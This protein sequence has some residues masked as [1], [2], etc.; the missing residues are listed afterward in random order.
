N[1]KVGEPA[2]AD[3]STLKAHLPVTSTFVCAAPRTAQIAT[4]S[5]TTAPTAVIR[6]YILVISSP[7][8]LLRVGIS[9]LPVLLHQYPLRAGGLRV[10]GMLG[11]EGERLVR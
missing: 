8:F 5:I 2:P 3:V 7:S 1:V 10:A 11:D 6:P 4:T 9:V